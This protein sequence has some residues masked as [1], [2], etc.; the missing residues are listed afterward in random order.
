MLIDWMFFFAK[1]VGMKTAVMTKKIYF[2]V[3]AFIALGILGIQIYDALDSDP[4]TDIGKLPT[5]R[6]VSQQQ[7]AVKSFPSEVPS[8]SRQP[9]KSDLDIEKHTHSDVAVV[10]NWLKRTG[11][12][13]IP[14]A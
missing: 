13:P 2:S 1:L 5:Q 10:D 8:D 6:E 3:A 14:H 12:S 7:H 4:L 11:F 9:E